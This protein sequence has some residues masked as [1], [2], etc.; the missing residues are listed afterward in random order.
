MMLH[1]TTAHQLAAERQRQLLDHSSRHR[2]ARTAQAARSG[3]AA[4]AARAARRATATRI[5]PYLLGRVRAV[6][7]ST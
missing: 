3:R 7:S 1:P 5:R 6:L 2:Q 4:R